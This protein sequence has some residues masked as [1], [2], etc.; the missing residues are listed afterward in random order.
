MPFDIYICLPLL[1]LVWA[2]LG[3]SILLQIALFHAFL[4]PNSIAF[5]IYIH[6]IFKDSIFGFSFS[7]SLNPVCSASNKY[8]A[9]IFLYTKAH[10][11]LTNPFL[12]SSLSVGQFQ[13]LP[14]SFLFLHTP[15]AASHFHKILTRILREVVT[16]PD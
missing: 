14:Y 11:P 9:S 12:S 2:S 6:R 16:S 5:Y 7:E 3:S 10:L 15:G 8:F 13:Q 4:E 1:H